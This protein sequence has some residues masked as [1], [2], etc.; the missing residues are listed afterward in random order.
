[1]SLLAKETREA[2]WNLLGRIPRESWPYHQVPV[3]ARGRFT[4]PQENETYPVIL[5][6]TTNEEGPVKS[7]KS[8]P[9]IIESLVRVGIQV[10]MEN[11]DESVIMDTLDDY[12]ELLRRTLLEDVEFVQTLEGLTDV[13]SS[14]QF[15]EEGSPF[16]GAVLVEFTVVGSE[17][18]EP[19]LLSELEAIRLNVD[20]IDPGAGP[21][22]TPEA[23]MNFDL[24]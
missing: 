4:P 1:M 17:V 19:K 21:D 5:V 6:K 13:S 7:G 23:V 14:T 15:S 2:V 9:P 8:G 12:D 11:R 10:Y 18:Y 22:G 20:L 16:L 3:L 24:T